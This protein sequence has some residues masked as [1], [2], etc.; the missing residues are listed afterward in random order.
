[1]NA[2]PV[3]IAVARRRLS[4][5]KAQAVHP[6]AFGFLPAGLWYHGCFTLGTSLL[7]WLLVRYAWPTQIERDAEGAR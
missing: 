1:M 6:M 3:A 2:S 7:M 4:G 5:E